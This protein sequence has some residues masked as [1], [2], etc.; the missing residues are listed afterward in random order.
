MVKQRILIVDDE[1]KIVRILAANLKSAGYET[2][3]A[4]N[5]K[6]A[7][8]LLELT[9]P[10]LVILDVM[11]P[12]MDGFA[13]L[14]RMRGFSETPVILLTARDQSED[15]VR[16]LNMGADD[17]LTK[18]FAIDEVFARVGAVLR[19][20]GRRALQSAAPRIENGAVC[21]DLREGRVT[22]GSEEIRFTG[23]EYRLFVL[24]MQNLG[25][26]MTHEYLLE[27]IWGAEY[28]GEIEY[29]R[30]AIAR[31]RR[32]LRNCGAADGYIRTYSGIGYLIEKIS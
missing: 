21:L 26:I 18:P 25:K 20:T 5:G 19:R 16:G 8:R 9:D 17:Y 13:V 29:L 14:E 7:L 32:K 12:E 6:E 23:T 3:S 11:M 27:E 30:V 22:A 28:I 2:H 24:L 15:K 1:P 10:D 31:I 4:P